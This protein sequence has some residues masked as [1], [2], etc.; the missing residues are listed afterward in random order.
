ME[1]VFLLYSFLFNRITFIIYAK[2]DF[3]L[4]LRILIPSHIL[5]RV[6]LQYLKEY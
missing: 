1:D 2:Y 5:L 4:L 3:F 6:S